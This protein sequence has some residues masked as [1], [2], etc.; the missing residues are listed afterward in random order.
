MNCTKAIVYTSELDE[1]R[2]QAERSIKESLVEH[3]EYYFKQLRDVWIE[4]LMNN[5]L[6]L[7]EQETKNENDEDVTILYGWLPSFGIV[8]NA[9]DSKR[10]EKDEEI[11]KQ[12]NLTGMEYGVQDSNR[13]ESD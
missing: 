13:P 10:F 7:E 2:E 12:Y 1:M 9:E 4:E 11:Y 6:R 8:L 3:L 5:R